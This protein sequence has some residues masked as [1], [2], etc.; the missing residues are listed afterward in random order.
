VRVLMV[1]TSILPDVMG[2][3]ERVIAEL[4]RALARRRHEIA[5]LAPRARRPAGDDPAGILRYRDPFLSFGTLYLPSLA[6]GRAAIARRLRDWRP[7]VVHAHHPIAGVAAAAATGG[8]CC[9]TFYGPW[10][11]EFLSEMAK[12]DDLPAAKRWTR[13]LWTPAKAALVRRLERRAARRARELVVLSAFSRDQIASVHG[14][15]AAGVTVIPGGVDPERFS[16]APARAAVRAALGWPAADPVLF[17]VRRLVPR[18]GLEN[19]LAA[20][21]RLPRARLVIAGSGWYRAQLEAAA[22]RLGV[23][24]RVRFAGFVPDEALPRY[25]QAADL[26]VLPSVALEGFGLITLEALACG[27]PVVATPEGGAAE[28]LAPLDPAWLA[29]DAQP[30]SLAEAIASAL[31]RAESDAALAAR[32]RAHAAGY[33][34]DAVAERYER[35]YARLA[36]GRP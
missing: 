23:A 16:P 4:G 13:A 34:W 15:P 12:R 30:P 18:M 20:L 6:L 11:L 19:L 26:A 29:R 2:G 25:Y 17:T 14:V 22:A 10:H 31:A 3:T 8:R 1:A 24:D 32:C 5:V 28:V 33:A 27:T 21:P 7:D 35:V 36:G 9:Y